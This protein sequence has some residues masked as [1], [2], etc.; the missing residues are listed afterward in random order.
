MKTPSQYSV[1]DSLS[2]TLWHLLW[3]TCCVPQTGSPLRRHLRQAARS[4]VRHHGTAQP[5]IGAGSFGLLYQGRFRH[6]S[7]LFALPIF[8]ENAKIMDND[9]DLLGDRDAEEMNG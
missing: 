2:F 4:M 5:V 3:L 7:A 9:L 8:A 6:R 1:S